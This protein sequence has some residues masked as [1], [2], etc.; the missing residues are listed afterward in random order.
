MDDSVDDGLFVVLGATGGIGRAVVSEALARGRRVRAVSRSAG[1]AADLP[2]GV[3]V[4]RTDLATPAGA[5][6]AVAGA[7]VVIHAAQPA[8]T[9]WGQEFPAL[10]ARIADA[11]AAA[12]ATL[13]FADNLYM[14]GLQPGGRPMTETTPSAATDQ[15]GRVRAAMAADLLDRCARGDLRVTIGRASDYYGPHGVTTALGAT[16]FPAA[17]RGRTA[18]VIGSVDAPHTMSYLPDIAA[19]LLTLGERDTAVGRAWH[20]PAAEPLTIR[21]FADLVA[22]EIERPVR[23]RASGPAML[24]LLGLAVP[25]VRELAGVA[26]QWQHPFVID[27]S[28]FRAAFPE[29]VHVTPHRDAVAVT[30]RWWRDRERTTATA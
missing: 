4:L 29:V 14:Y 8:Y 18:N 28:A 19:G 21:Q 30:T 20:L 27:D 17:L 9:R 24:R 5:A 12:G 26:Y 13:V 16:L 15:K 10:T 6:G 7:A 11:T 1:S 23:L 3:E 2:A 25:M 22:A